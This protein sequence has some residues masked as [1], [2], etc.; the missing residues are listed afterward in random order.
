MSPKH[1]T[2]LF[3]PLRDLARLVPS[4]A[5]DYRTAA[6]AGAFLIG[7]GKLSIAWGVALAPDPRSHVARA[8]IGSDLKDSSHGFLRGL[9]LCYSMGWRSSYDGSSMLPVD[10]ASLTI[11]HLVERSSTRESTTR[12]LALS[13]AHPFPFFMDGY[14]YLAVATGLLSARYLDKGETSADDLISDFCRIEANRWKAGS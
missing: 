2:S 1:G 12:G 9:L 3:A 7:H 4:A 14:A 10:R 11:A 5:P 13:G 8:D 6:I